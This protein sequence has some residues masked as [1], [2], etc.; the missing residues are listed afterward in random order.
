MGR[1]AVSMVT[2]RATPTTFLRRSVQEPIRPRMSWHETW[3]GPD[4]G[5]IRCWEVGRELAVTRDYYPHAEG[6]DPE[7]SVDRARRGEL[8]PL[9]WRGGIEPPAP[10]RP[11]ELAKKP[12]KRKND[13]TYQYLAMWQGLRG[14]DLDLPLDGRVVLT[15]ARL[16][17]VVTFRLAATERHASLV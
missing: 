2:R 16:K 14:E 12:P 1:G 15:C 7:P 17:T 8:L 11:G 13:G 10:P 4:H 6:A 9:G 3:E 5:L